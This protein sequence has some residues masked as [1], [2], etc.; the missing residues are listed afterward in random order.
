MPNIAIPE[1]H[2]DNPIGYAIGNLAPEQ[3]GPMYDFSTAVYKHSRLPLREFEAARTAIALINGCRICQN[4]RS[5]EDVPTYLEGLGEDPL[6]GVHRNGPAPDEEFYAN[7]GNWRDA[8]I[9]S[10]RERLAIDF[11]ER[12]SLEPDALGHDAAFWVRLK[13]AFSEAEIYELTVAC[14]C[15]VAAGRFVHVLGFDEGAVCDIRKEAAE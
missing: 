3:T 10:E 4:F 15:L 1:D 13:A 5:A 14:A 7:I 11:A 6:S 9:Y 2:L 8:G 12:F